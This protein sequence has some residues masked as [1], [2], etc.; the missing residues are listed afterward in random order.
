MFTR[1]QAV[2]EGVAAGTLAVILPNS[3]RRLPCPRAWLP[4]CLSAGT[5]TAA[6]NDHRNPSVRCLTRYREEAASK[7]CADP[8]PKPRGHWNWTISCLTSRI[9]VPSTRSRACSRISLIL[10]L[11][12]RPRPP[13]PPGRGARDVRNSDDSPQERNLLNDRMPSLSV[14]KDSGEDRDDD[15]TSIRSRISLKVALEILQ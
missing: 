2:L 15:G 3:S 4:V 10:P 9:A 12:A 8:A 14:R 7:R 13:W 1:R 6:A 5:L 11:T